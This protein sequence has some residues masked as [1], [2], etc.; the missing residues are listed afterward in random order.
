MVDLEAEHP[1]L[2]TSAFGLVALLEHWQSHIAAKTDASAWMQDLE[3]AA[4]TERLAGHLRAV[5]NLAS[6][7]LFPSALVVCRTALEHHVLDRLLLLANRYRL[8][9]PTDADEDRDRLLAEWEAQEGDWTKQVE[10][11]APT[12]RG[13]RLVRRGHA[14]INPEGDVVEQISPYWLAME[15]YDAL[16][17]HPS[18]QEQLLRPFRELEDSVKWAKTSQQLYSEYFKWG[19]LCDNLEL[20]DLASADEILQLQVHYRFLSAF[21]HA[22]NTGYNVAHRDVRPNSPSA[23]H[24]LSELALLYVAVVASAQID[25]WAAFLAKRSERLRPLGAEVAKIAETARQRIGYFWFLGGKPQPFDVYEEANRRAHPLLLEGKPIPLMTDVV[26]EDVRYYSDPYDRLA[27][28]HVGE[29][30][31]TTGFAFAPLWP[32][33]HW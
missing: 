17:G 18:T 3:F 22:T 20:N 28:L 6:A 7:E 25:T 21:T 11:L 2:A 13:L 23:T 8:D 33:L 27:R 16:A 26:P 5:L 12:K 15:H 4:R 32:S 10:S 9:F 29:R 1:T 19:A 14:V 30:E 24:L 31:L